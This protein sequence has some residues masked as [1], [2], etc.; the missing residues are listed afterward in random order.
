MVTPPW[1][2]RPLDSGRILTLAPITLMAWISMLAAAGLLA[3]IS[4][5][6]SVPVLVTVRKPDGQ[7]RAL[8]RRLDGDHGRIEG[9]HA[10]GLEV[11]HA[12][13]TQPDRPFGIVGHVDE[14]HALQVLERL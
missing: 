8:H 10:L 6:G 3:P 9:E 7:A 2:T 1:M 12:D 14:G 13:G 11:A 4:R 5:S